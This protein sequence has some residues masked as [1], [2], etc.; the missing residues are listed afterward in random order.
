MKKIY[1]IFLATVLTA[2]TGEEANIFSSSAAERLTEGAAMGEERLTSSPAGWAMEYYPTTDTDAP[3]GLGYLMLT[4]FNADGSVTMAMNNDFSSNSYLEDTS[5]WEVI[6]DNGIV[7]TYNTYNQCIHAFCDPEDISSTSSSDETGYGCEGD[8]EFIM[9]DIDENDASPEYLTLKGK[10]RG[11]YVRLSR[12]DEGTVFEDYMTDIMAFNSLMF[13]SSAPNYL[14]MTLGDDVYQIDDVASGI[15]NIYPWGTDDIANE[16]YHPYLTLKHNGDYRFRFRDAWESSDGSAVQEFVYDEA[17]D[18]FFDVNNSANSICGPV[19]AEFMIYEMEEGNYW[20]LRRTSDMGTAAS[21]LFENVYSGL[22]TMNY[23]L[24]YIR[25][26]FSDSDLVCAFSIKNSKNAT[27]IVSYKF[28]YAQ[29]GDNITFAYVEP[30]NSS[31]ST[32]YN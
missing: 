29:D 20:T 1:F 17:Q 24:Q 8:Y 26:M 3:Y 5:C 7:L 28:T 31:S 32:V 27:S 12:L 30:L 22:S 4:D 21:T 15:P 19:P 23:T 16:S 18:C 11:V 25:F 13:S 6:T 2:C 9:V 14:V 10:K